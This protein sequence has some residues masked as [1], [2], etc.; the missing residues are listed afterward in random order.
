MRNVIVQGIGDDV[1]NC[2]AGPNTPS[3]FPLVGVGAVVNSPS[4]HGATDLCIT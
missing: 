4:R 1:R 2:S 3:I